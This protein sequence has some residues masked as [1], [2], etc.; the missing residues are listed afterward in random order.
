MANYGVAEAKAKF[1]ELIDR[2][3]QGETIVILRHGK[4]V[5][6]F[7]PEPAAEEQQN[8]A[9]K[10]PGKVDVAAL[11]KGLVKQRKGALSAVEAVRRMRNEQRF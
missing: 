11:R 9:P 10:V 7:T 6:R 5:I 4:P 8:T 2:A 1:S 3:Q